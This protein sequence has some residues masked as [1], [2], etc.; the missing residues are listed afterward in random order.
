MV[1]DGESVEVGFAKDSEF[2][3]VGEEIPFGGRNV[4]GF[5]IFDGDFAERGGGGGGRGG[6]RGVVGEGLEKG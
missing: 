2:F 6:R 1:L 3:D 4:V 5:G